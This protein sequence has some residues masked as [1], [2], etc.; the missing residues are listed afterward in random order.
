MSDI[1]H[2]QAELYKDSFAFHGSLLMVFHGLPNLKHIQQKDFLKE[3]KSK[4]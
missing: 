2:F 4:M 3:R 1:L